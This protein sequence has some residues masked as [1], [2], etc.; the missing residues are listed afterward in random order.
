MFFD[1]VDRWYEKE[2][3]KC[4]IFTNN[5][6][7]SDLFEFLYSVDNGYLG[8]FP[9]HEIMKIKTHG[10]ATCQNTDHEMNGLQSLKPLQDPG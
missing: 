5:K 1:M 6:Q 3:P 10:G 8:I 4:M 9:D 2:G 7:P